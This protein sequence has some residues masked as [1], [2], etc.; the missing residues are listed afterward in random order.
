MPDNRVELAQYICEVGRDLIPLLKAHGLDST[1]HCLELAVNS[2]S[3]VLNEEVGD[4]EAD[5]SAL[6]LD[7]TSL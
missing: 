2:A 4:K 1:A 6:K 3:Q 5:T 7:R